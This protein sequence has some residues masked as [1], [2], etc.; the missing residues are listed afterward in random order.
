MV[1]SAGVQGSGGNKFWPM[2]AG[3]VC[4]LSTL[5]SHFGF[6]GSGSR[7]LIRGKGRSLEQ[8]YVYQL[9]A[10]VACFAISTP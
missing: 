10:F 9:V 4:D 1:G 6:E 5:V 3:V 7:A 8:G 2:G